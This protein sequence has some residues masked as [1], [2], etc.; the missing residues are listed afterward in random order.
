MAT[1]ILYQRQQELI[2][3]LNE[4][5]DDYEQSVAKVKA[6][7]DQS[8]ANADKQWRTSQ[9]NIKVP[10]DNI[11]ALETS[12]ERKLDEAG[13]NLT[14]LQRGKFDGETSATGLVH[15]QNM[16]EYLSIARK[17]SAKLDKPPLNE[18]R[19]FPPLIWV[20]I[21]SILVLFV[22]GVIARISLLPVITGILIILGFPIA[23]LISP[24]FE[25]QKRKT[26]YAAI[27][28][29]VVTAERLAEQ[30]RI[31]DQL[32]YHQQ[33]A[34]AKKIY[35]E[36]MEKLERLLARNLSSL[37]SK[38]EEYSREAGL[39]GADWQDT[40]WQQWRPSTV[41][42]PI[43]RLGS[44]ALR[45]PNVEL[46]AFPLFV[47]FPGERNL[48]LKTAGAVQN[49]ATSAIQ[50]L[51]LRLFATQPPGMIRFTFIDT[52]EFGRSIAPF[53]QLASVDESLVAGRIW[54]EASHIEKQLADLSEYMTLINQKYLWG[55]YTTIEEYNGRNRNAPL[56]YRILVVLGFPFKFTPET[57]RTL[58]N[59]A[60]NGP[61]CGVCV[62]VVWDTEQRLIQGFNVSDLERV[63]TVIAWQGQQI[64]WEGVKLEKLVQAAFAL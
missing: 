4:L 44:L 45:N 10:L 25:R 37:K 55:P 18:S 63:S 43:T 8:K 28:Q 32:M 64:I 1:H 21:G 23:P 33:S 20:A 30:R 11:H 54:T 9:K 17:Y 61:P 15:V 41:M 34:A 6:L 26:C 40:V 50:S 52:A 29:A 35:Q 47:P 48:L 19:W 12:V 5:F 16:I 56:P 38:I 14:R 7:F 24:I 62:A 60:K 59:I 22:L 53:M 27:K 46:P 57:A 42:I 31:A 2:Q 51:I 39:M 13:V 3:R 49:E 36:Q 58:L